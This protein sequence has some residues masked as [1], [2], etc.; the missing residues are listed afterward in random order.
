MKITINNKQREIIL[1]A[2]E[3]I[4]TLYDFENTTLKEFKD[5]YGLSK[6]DLIK[7]TQNLKQALQSPTTAENKTSKGLV[8]PI[9]EGVTIYDK[10]QTR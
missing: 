1:K 7:E 6:A 3:N 2:V 9:N 4:T 10:P 8:L 5:T